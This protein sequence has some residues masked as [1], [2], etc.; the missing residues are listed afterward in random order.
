MI[1]VSSGL[2]A[3]LARLRELSGKQLGEALL[4]SLAAQPTMVDE[5]DATGDHI[6]DP[7]LLL[8]AP[9]GALKPAAVLVVVNRAAPEPDLVLTVRTTT[10]SAHAG[11]IAFPGGRMDAGEGPVETALREAS[12]E[13]GLPPAAVEICGHLPSYASR[14][15]YRV[16]PVV[17][18]VDGWPALRANRGEV[19]EIFHVPARFL[20]DPANARLEARQVEGQSR[21]F[22][23]YAYRNRLIWGLT[24]GIVHHMSMRLIE[25]WS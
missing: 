10:L 24:A 6:L 18:A 13:I 3:A 22:Y 1:E 2:T 19:D 20:L 21:S 5:C 14:T 25:K 12:E 16:F 9:R 17:G 15:G 23:A 11:Q 8:E 7:G 4:A